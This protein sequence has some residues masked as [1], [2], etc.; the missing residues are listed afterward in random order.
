MPR[1]PQYDWLYYRRV[2]VAGND[3]LADLARLPNAPS[4]GALKK[5]SRKEDWP[6]QRD[7]YVH[8]K[9]SKSLDLASTT[10][11]EVAARHARIARAMQG[12]ALE[13]LR[14]MPV[15]E[16]S[17]A[18]VR[19]YLRDAAEIERRALGLDTV[20]VVNLSKR[21]EDMTDDELRAAM[22]AHGISG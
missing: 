5:T 8:Q 3:S 13:R 1:P 16:M 9:E 15:S 18:E 22:R 10:E 19:A 17:A 14:D 4:L 2:Y 21:P 20:R 6:G 12:K 7:A 11:A